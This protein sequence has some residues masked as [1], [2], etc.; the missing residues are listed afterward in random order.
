MCAKNVV[1]GGPQGSRKKVVQ[2]A[3]QLASG[4]RPRE[5]KRAPEQLA[6][7]LAVQPAAQPRHPRDRRMTK[8]ACKNLKQKS[9][10]TCKDSSAPTKLRKDVEK[11]CITSE[12]CAESFASQQGFWGVGRS[13]RALVV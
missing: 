4:R 8:T 7:Q 13:S 11:E 2:L 1:D 5:R 9:K 12:L 6:V 10:R 3:V